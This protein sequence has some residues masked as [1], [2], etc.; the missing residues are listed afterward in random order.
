MVGSSSA[1]ASRRWVWSCLTIAA[2]RACACWATVTWKVS[3]SVGSSRSR[4]GSRSRA[5]AALVP[6]RHSTPFATSRCA[7]YR[8]PSCS[9]WCAA[10]STCSRVVRASISSAR[11]RSRAG[12]GWVG[13]PGAGSLLVIVVVPGVV[14]LAAVG[15]GDRVGARVAGQLV[16]RPTLVGIR[17]EGPD[18]AGWVG[19]LHGGGDRHGGVHAVQGPQQAGFAAGVGD[20]QQ[21]RVA[22]AEPGEGLVAFQLADD[23]G[24]VLGGAVQFQEENNRA[25]AVATVDLP[26]AVP[27]W[28]D[29]GAAVGV[30]GVAFGPPPQQTRVRVAAVVGVQVDEELVDAE[31]MLG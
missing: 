28:M 6:P 25:G 23:A 24:E 4:G 3:A 16:Q 7:S 17:G 30:G 22:G 19:L 15:V 8:M 12:R 9:R 1:V 29:V 11:S 10:A 27:V 21:H 20:P 18:R 13:R 2:A 5:R 26:D 31:E 14:G